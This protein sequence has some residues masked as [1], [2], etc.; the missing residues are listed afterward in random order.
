MLLYSHILHHALVYS[1]PHQLPKQLKSLGLS[2]SF[3]PFMCMFPCLSVTLERPILPYKRAI[4]ILS[5][6]LEVQCIHFQEAT[7][8]LSR[9]Q[10]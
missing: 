8:C 1:F 2:L 4:S 3:S 9:I 10:C 7:M 6:V 5:G